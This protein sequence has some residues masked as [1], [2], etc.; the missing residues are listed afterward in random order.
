M[1]FAR[2]FP[3]ALVGLRP[4]AAAGKAQ[5]PALTQPRQEST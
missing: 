1:I 4:P 2:A 5:S 3:A